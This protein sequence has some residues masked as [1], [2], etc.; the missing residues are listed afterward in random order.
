[1]IELT[2]SGDAEA[3]AV[4]GSVPFNTVLQSCAC[5]EKYR[6]GSSSIILAKP[7]RYLISASANIGAGAANTTVALGIA[8]NGEVQNGTVMEATSVV[9]GQY[10]NV[11]AQ[12]YVDVF[13]CCCER[14]SLVNAGDAALGVEN[15]NLIATRVG[16][17]CY[18]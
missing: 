2:Y 18:A 17:I 15:Q 10:N 13:P 4:G 3:V 16:G 12:K 6:P 1:M 14:V 9:A 7:G 5:A 8:L 11:A